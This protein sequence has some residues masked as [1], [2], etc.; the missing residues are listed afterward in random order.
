MGDFDGG[1]FFRVIEVSL[2]DAGLGEERAS[3]HLDF[4]LVLL[5]LDRNR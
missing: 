3:G 2:N 5:Q 4:T 1:D